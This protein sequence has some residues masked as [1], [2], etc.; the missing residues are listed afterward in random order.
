MCPHAPELGVE[1]AVAATLEVCES[2]RAASSRDVADLPCHGQGVPLPPDGGIEVM[3]VFL[4]WEAGT[5]VLLPDRYDSAWEIGD[6]LA[7]IAR[8]IAADGGF[9]D[10]EEGMNV[11]EI[12]AEI[13]LSFHHATTC[14]CQT[15]PAED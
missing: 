3:R 7:D 14:Q 4:G 5:Y 15:K 11:D 9:G 13:L 12:L 1:P 6:L 2:G 8:D 10:K